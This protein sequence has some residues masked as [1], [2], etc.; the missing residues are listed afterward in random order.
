LVVHLN[1]DDHA[2]RPES[3]EITQHRITIASLGF[4]VSAIDRMQ[5]GEY[6]GEL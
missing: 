4:F 5:R 6:C 1:A 2:A 3:S